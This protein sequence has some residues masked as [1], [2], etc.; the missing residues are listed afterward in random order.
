M[1]SQTICLSYDVARPAN[2][3]DILVNE[4]GAWN[5]ANPHAR[6]PDTGEMIQVGPV[7]NNRATYVARVAGDAA[8]A[9][10]L[11]EQEERLGLARGVLRVRRPAVSF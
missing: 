7:W 3:P 6:A 8:V 9:A 10:F 2:G 11:R 5:E 1:T 4:T